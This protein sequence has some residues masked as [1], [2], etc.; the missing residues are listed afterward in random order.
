MTRKTASAPP[1]REAKPRPFTVMVV[2]DEDDLR[3][4][5]VELLASA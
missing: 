3:D 5:L 4:S 1:R 2:D